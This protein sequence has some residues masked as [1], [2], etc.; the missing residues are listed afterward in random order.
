VVI[1]GQGGLLTQTPT[2]D[3]D[4]VLAAISRLSPDGGTS[5]RQA[6]LTGLGAI[7]GEP[8]NLPGE[9]EQPPDLGYWGSATMIVFSDGQDAAPEQ[10]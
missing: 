3:H 6:I 5:L 9:G 10:S 4:A 1:F 7:T 2:A 8:V